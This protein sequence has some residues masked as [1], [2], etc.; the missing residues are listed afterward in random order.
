MRRRTVSISITVLNPFSD[1]P[2][3]GARKLPAAPL[4]RMLNQNYSSL[5]L[6]GF[7]YIPQITKS[8]LPNLEMVS[9]TA[10]AN[11]AVSRTSVCTAIQVFPVALESSSAEFL[12]LPR[13]MDS[14]RVRQ[15]PRRGIARIDGIPTF[16]PRSQH[17]PHDP[18]KTQT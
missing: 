6:S 18:S 16:S 13:L 12:N 4:G 7:W 14:I 2:E 11:C 8:I 5:Q 1:K 9:L 10:V 3:I 17:W 15:T